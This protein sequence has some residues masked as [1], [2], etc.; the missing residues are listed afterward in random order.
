MKVPH[1]LTFCSSKLQACKLFVFLIDTQVPW[2][3][4]GP[5]IYPTQ[6]CTEW[7]LT[8]SYTITFRYTSCVDMYDICNFLLWSLVLHV[9]PQCVPYALREWTP[10]AFNRTA[11]T[12]SISD[13]MLADCVEALIGASY[14]IG[15]VKCALQFM[16][17]VGIPVKGCQM[18]SCWKYSEPQERVKR[19]EDGERKRIVPPDYFDLDGEDSLPDDGDLNTNYITSHFNI[20]HFG[21]SSF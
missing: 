15:N 11:P 5:S 4:P 12:K 14:L 18:L 13:K 7:P 3:L 19:V 10:V 21:N 20:N 9:I 1:A 16:S 6:I 8:R 17:W 2:V